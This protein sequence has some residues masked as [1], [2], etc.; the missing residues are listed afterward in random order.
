MSFSCFVSPCQGVS[1]HSSP[2]WGWGLL[3]GARFDPLV[4]LLLFTPQVFK[5]VPQNGGLNY[6][7]S[8]PVFEQRYSTA[9]TQTPP[10]FALPDDESQLGMLTV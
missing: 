9:S 2:L 1:P 5:A 6:K 8:P 10:E 3:I 4:S 7:P